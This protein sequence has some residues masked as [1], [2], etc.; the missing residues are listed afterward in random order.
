MSHC[1]VTTINNPTKSIEKLYEIFG[2]NLIVVG[3]VKTPSDWNYK[4]TTYIPVDRVDNK[5]WFEGYDPINHY[6]RK[7]IGYLS[8]IKSGAS[9]ILDIDDDTYPTEGWKIR[10][11]NVGAFGANEEGWYNVYAALSDAHIW[12][13]GFSLKELNKMPTLTRIEH[14]IKSSIQQGLVDGDPDVDAI[15]RLVSKEKRHFFTK[16]KS[17]CLPS[18]SFCPFNSQATCWLPDAYP[19]MY[20]PVCSTFRMCDIWRSFIAQRCLW[21]IGDYVTFHSPSEFYQERNEHD[22]LADFEDE[23]PGY[24]H[25]DRIVEILTGLRLKGGKENMCENLLTCYQ[26]IVDENILPEMEMRSVKSWIKD[27]E[28]IISNME[29]TF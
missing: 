16:N 21:M 29:G 22:L 8:A 27:Y 13:R 11:N 25:N 12:P 23:V 4:N 6:A 1:V 24:L 5:G 18:F 26:V 17:I 3:D 9:S 14:V 15:W 10:E 20:L 7:N 2:S 28:K 19:L